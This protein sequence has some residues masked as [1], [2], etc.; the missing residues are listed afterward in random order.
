M[1]HYNNCKEFVGS[2]DSPDRY[3]LITKLGDGSQGTVWQA[4][5]DT[6]A[7]CAIKVYHRA[8]TISSRPLEE[9]FEIAKTTV[10]RLNEI[11]ATGIPKFYEPFFGPP[12][13]GRGA[14]D[15]YVGQ[16][17]LYLVTQIEKGDEIN[18]YCEGERHAHRRLRSLQDAGAALDTLHAN[19]LVHGDIKPNNIMVD[20]ETGA[21]TLVDFDLTRRSDG[22]DEMR[23]VAGAPGYMDPAL[24]ADPQYVAANDVYAFAVT[25]AFAYA[26]ESPRSPVGV[27]QFVHQ[28]LTAGGYDPQ[29]VEILTRAL[30]PRPQDRGEHTS[31][32]SLLAA[33]R[34]ITRTTPTTQGAIAG[35]TVLPP[36][37]PA[38]PTALAPPR[39]ARRRRTL[40]LLAAAT[41]AIGVGTAGLLV[42]RN[43]PAAEQG[44]ANADAEPID[45]EA[46]VPSSTTT[47]SETTQPTPS[48]TT[49]STTTS[50][51]TTTIP[52][53]L[54]PS[55]ANKPAAEAEQELLALGLQPVVVEEQ[56]VAPF[57]TDPAALS[58]T[59]PGSTVTL[60]VAAPPA[61]M[62]DLVGGSLRS[63]EATLSDLDIT[64]AVTEAYVEGAQDSIVTAQ[65]PDATMPYATEV[66]L[67][68]QRRPTV[69]Y[70]AD[71][72]E[73]DR[74]REGLGPLFGTGT[75]RI[76][77]EDYPRSVTPSRL[78]ND[79]Y[80]VDYDLRGSYYRLRGTFGAAS[81]STTDVRMR[82]E[83]IGDNGVVLFNEE[84]VL[85]QELNV[86]VDVTGQFRVRLQVTR[87]EGDIFN[88]P[89]FGDVRVLGT[90][91]AL[92]LDPAR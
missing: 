50:S 59:P 88:Q 81:D 16:G 85:S 24:E 87:L 45:V 56:G 43:T 75:G 57:G 14:A 26:G 41:L 30:A 86:D 28:R 3:G 17:D 44:A 68:I 15:G 52:L 10:D 6:G 84:A 5:T 79:P 7:R 67:S 73:A 70:L 89:I 46:T 74:S 48:E 53:V 71:V 60:Y 13:H 34:M 47:V 33:V 31:A 36:P 8:S 62:P 39:P 66:A 22:S 61:L 65:T 72:Q 2:F 51:T 49:T 82:F 21:S 91:D 63:A 83:V 19:G 69:V 64:P 1:S 42:V 76:A 40:M 54:I 38:P 27:P 77:A 92:P 9:R 90:D 32:G 12:V 80:W 37:A 55:L 20:P 23:T 78:G 35:T 58:N 18:D 11:V 4:V 29:I 25:L